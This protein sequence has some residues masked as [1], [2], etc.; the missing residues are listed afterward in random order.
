MATGVIPY[1]Y[2]GFLLHDN[3][4][5]FVEKVPLEWTVV[6]PAMTKIARLEGMKKNGETIDDKP[7]VMMI[8]VI[9][10]SGLRTDLETAL[11]TLDIALNKRA[12][13]LVLHS[14][15]RYWVADCIMSKRVLDKP[16]Y[17]AMELDFE[18]YQPFALAALPS[19]AT[20]SGTLSGSGPYILAA[21]VV[22]G[23]TVFSRPTITV[24][25]TGSVT[26]TNL[27]LINLTD[28][29][30][31]SFTPALSLVANDVLTVV[32]DPFAAN[33]NGYTIYKNG[34]LTTLYDFSGTFPSLD[35]GTSSWQVQCFGASAPTASV[36]FAWT[37]RYLG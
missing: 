34:V 22:S 35:V 18:V 19:T 29:V 11:D 12:Q 20:T 5:F 24:T 16:S 32:C 26:M 10:P 13:P 15:G 30:L 33:N 31:L 21:T 28:N 17:V 9:P 7:M 27:S 14:D 23:G 37:N 25:N 6:T 3:I 1:S 4:T 2:G 8:S 36:N